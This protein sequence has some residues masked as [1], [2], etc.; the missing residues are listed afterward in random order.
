MYKQMR[1]SNDCHNLST[2]QSLNL[3]KIKI[4]VEGPN[5]IADEQCALLYFI[6]TILY[7]FTN[8]KTIIF[9]SYKDHKVKTVLD[10]VASQTF[11]VFT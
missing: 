11:V 1:W 6:E 7:I 2:S 9:R 5:Y 8:F 4:N 3:R 10:F